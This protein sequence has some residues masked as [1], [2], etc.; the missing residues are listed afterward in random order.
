MKAIRAL[1]K[2]MLLTLAWAAGIAAVVGGL[3]LLAEQEGRRYL[4]SEE[5]ND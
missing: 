4:I 5:F 2:C 1:V 3:S